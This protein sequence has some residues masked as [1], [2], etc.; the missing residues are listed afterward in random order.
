M[1]SVP[2]ASL[3]TVALIAG[4]GLRVPA[5]LVTGC[6]LL[7]GTVVL[8]RSFLDTIR[9]SEGWGR[10]LGAILLLWLELLVVGVGVGVGLVTYPLGQRY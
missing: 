5:L 8:N 4:F 7:A 9:T 6:A 3:G 1:A 10:V 2:L